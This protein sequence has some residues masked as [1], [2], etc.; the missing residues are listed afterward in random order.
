MSLGHQGV[1]LLPPGELWLE[2]AGPLAGQQTRLSP[3]TPVVRGGRGLEILLERVGGLLGQE[4]PDGKRKI[5]NFATAGRTY[6]GIVELVTVQSHSSVQSQLIERD[7]SKQNIIQLSRP[8]V[9]SL[10]SPLLFPRH[11]QTH[12]HLT[13]SQLSMFKSININTHL[14]SA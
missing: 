13:I 9:P 12:H 4:K 8:G 2:G 10:L 14:L 1:E 6:W 11:H 5:S 3:V 7:H